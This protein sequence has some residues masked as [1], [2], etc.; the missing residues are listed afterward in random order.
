MLLGNPLGGPF[1]INR[2]FSD[3]TDGGEEAE[4]AMSLSLFQTGV[5]K[6]SKRGPSSLS[7]VSDLDASSS[8][9]TWEIHLTASAMD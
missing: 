4:I 5:R 7:L 2:S 6:A 3:Q 9:A 1:G 8:L